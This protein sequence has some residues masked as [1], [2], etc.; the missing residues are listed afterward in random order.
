MKST[1]LID[2][3]VIVYALN[4][5]SQFHK[6]SKKVLDDA[7]NGK[8]QAS[9]CDKSL[10]ELYAIIT[11]GK[12]VEHPITINEAIDIIKILIN[13]EIHILL[14]DETSVTKTFELAKKYKII[15]QNI[16]DYV[17]VGMMLSNGINQLYTYNHKDF[18]K[19]K[20]ITLIEI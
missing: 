9:I 11:D 2:T 17:L 6:Q 15:K 18:S 19:I 12:R 7:L 8:I 20:E 4:T 5:E 16:F 13:S 14:S 1:S 10:F 3:N